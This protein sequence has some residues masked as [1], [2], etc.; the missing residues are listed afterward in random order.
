[1][2]RR[3]DEFLLSLPVGSE[4]VDLG[5]SR[6][7]CNS[8]PSCMW[9]TSTGVLLMLSCNARLCRCDATSVDVEIVSFSFFLFLFLQ[10]ALG[11]EVLQFSGEEC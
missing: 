6:F 8:V 11:S 3:V 2:S 9:M 1:M 10:R 4:S 5:K 7:S